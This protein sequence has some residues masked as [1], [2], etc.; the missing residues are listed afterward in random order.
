MCCP[1]GFR[2]PTPRTKILC[3][4]HY[5]IGQFVRILYLNYL[6]CS[7]GFEPVT[8]WLTCYIYFYINHLQHYLV[9]CCSLDYFFTIS[10]IDLGTS[11]IVSTPFMNNQYIQ[12]RESSP[13]EIFLYPRFRFVREVLL[14][15]FLLR[16]SYYCAKS[17][18][19][20]TELRTHHLLFLT[21]I[22]YQTSYR[23]LINSQKFIFFMIMFI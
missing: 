21:Y 14:L 3:T 2:T 23:N 18:A 19:L 15:K 20:P 6:V 8:P 5:T 22:I 12:F 11:C 1:I 13:K 9:R 10:I 17:S 4:S 16:H 7:A